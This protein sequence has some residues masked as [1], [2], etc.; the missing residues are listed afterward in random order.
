MKILLDTCTF[1]WSSLNSDRLSNKAKACFLDPNHELFLSVFSTWEIIAKYNAG[2]LSLVDSPIQFI[3]NMCL[4]NSIQVLPLYEEDV[5][6]LNNLPA[7]HK[8]PF[9]R[10]LICQAIAQ[11]MALLTPDPLITQYSIRTIW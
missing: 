10:M 9:N 7:L 5:K 3:E 4:N 2:R 8:D 6:Q 1:L 11:G